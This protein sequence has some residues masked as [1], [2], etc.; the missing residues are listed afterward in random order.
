[1]ML[2]AWCRFD[3]TADNTYLGLAGGYY[4]RDCSSEIE[5]TFL[6]KPKYILPMIV[7]VRRTQV[8]QGAHGSKRAFPWIFRTTTKAKVSVIHHSSRAYYN[9]VG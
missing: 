6:P 3:Y 4:V 9:S 8:H 1:M 7:K 5:M 2:S